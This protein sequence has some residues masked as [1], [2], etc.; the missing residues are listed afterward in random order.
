M[1]TISRTLAAAGIA[2]FGWAGTAQTAPV[3]IDLSIGVPFIFDGFGVPLSASESVFVT[4]HAHSGGAGG[5]APFASL[6]PRLLFL[7]G[8]GLGV[9]D[10][11]ADTPQLD[12]IMAPELAR[13]SFSTTVTLLSIIFDDAFSGD[14]FDMAVDEVDVDVA[15]LLGTDDID[16]LP[17]GGFGTDSNLA[18]FGG[19]LTGTMFDFYTTDAGDDYRIRQ[20][21]VEVIGDGPDDV[22]APATLLLLGLGLAGLRLARRRRF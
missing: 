12:G 8:E 10:E 4:G 13:F 22:P 21:V 15:G 18:D 6:S 7:N 1:K 20:L 11:D 3:V 19:G 14:E 2:L 5:D 17:E 16:D 9:F